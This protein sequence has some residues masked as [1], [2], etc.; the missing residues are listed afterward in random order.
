MLAPGTP[1]AMDGVAQVAEQAGGWVELPPKS[2]EGEVL[3]C[4]DLQ[5]PLDGQGLLGDVVA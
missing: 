4:S 3:D 1:T 2:E 5:H